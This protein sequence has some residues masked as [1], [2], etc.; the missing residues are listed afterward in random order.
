MQRHEANILKHLQPSQGS[1]NHR[2]DQ[3]LRCGGEVHLHG[4]GRA[5][6]EEA[7]QDR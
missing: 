4:G 3:R 5:R 7:E 6:E 1:R 2:A